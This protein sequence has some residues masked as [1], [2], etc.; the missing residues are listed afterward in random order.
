MTIT[1]YHVPRT[2]SSPIVQ[3]LMELDVLD[4]VTIVEKDFPSLKQQDY[5]SIN[6][7]GTVPALV[8]DDIAP[9]ILF[10]SGAILDYLLEKFDTENKLHPAPSTA[11]DEA[12]QRRAKYLQLKQFIIATAYPFIASLHIHVLFQPKEKHDPAYIESATHKVT[13]LL[14]P[15]LETALGENEF[16]LGDAMSAVDLLLCK[17]M[18]NLNELGLLEKSPSLQK[19]FQTIS[20]RR[21][22]FAKAY[23][24]QGI[25]SAPPSATSA[26]T[27]DGR[28]RTLVLVPSVSSEEGKVASE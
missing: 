6:P 12:Q 28:N 23:T 26:E 13:S 18:N 27:K 3:C 4:Q 2:I 11:S 16:L 19:L 20:N 14:I 15:V 17:P 7:M 9:V 21:P 22:S 24:K 1:L 10:E 25:V 8:D 5:L